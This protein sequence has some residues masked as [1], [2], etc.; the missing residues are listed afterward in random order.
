MNLVQMLFGSGSMT[1]QIQQVALS[2]LSGAVPG[3]WTRDWPSAPESP[4]AWLKELVR[5]QVALTRLHAR[6]DTGKLLL[7]PLSLSDLF[8]P[9]TF[10]SALRQL[11]A[12]ASGVP[13]DQLTMV[14]SWEDDSPRLRKCPHTCCLNGLLLQGAVVH[15]MSGSLREPKSGSSEMTSA[16]NVTIGFL[17]LSSIPNEEGGTVSVPVFLSPSREES[18]MELS[19]K[20]ET[21]VGAVEVDAKW[22]LAGVALFLRTDD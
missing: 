9:G 2:L 18:L 17:P 11:T 1:S 3:E 22:I 6:I 8:C 19:M 12:Q 21:S 4:Q 5:K 10:I 16:P 20:V 7:E 15:Q 13:M 14:C